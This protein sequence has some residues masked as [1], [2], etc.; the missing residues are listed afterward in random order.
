[1]ALA[2]LES[3][4]GLSLRDF[5]DPCYAWE[6]EWSF[7]ERFSWPLL[8]LVAWMA[9]RWELL[10]ALVFWNLGGPS[11]GAIHN[12]SYAWMLGWPFIASFS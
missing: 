9:L 1:M 2:M 11:L 5:H 12:P 4:D 6:F 10:K 8:C 3:L 7:V